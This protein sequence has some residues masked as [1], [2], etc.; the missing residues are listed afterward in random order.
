MSAQWLID[1]S[2]G[3]YSMACPRFAT[4]LVK[5]HRERT[6]DGLRD[7]CKAVALQLSDWWPEASGAAVDWE[8][9]VALRHTVTLPQKR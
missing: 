9:Q 8:M 3:E 1:L 5:E 6:R 4:Q 2:R 7:A